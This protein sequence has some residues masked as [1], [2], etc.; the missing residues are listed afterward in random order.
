MDLENLGQLPL[1]YVAFL[2]SLTFHE[3]A[4]SWAA[5]LG[6][7]LTAYHAGQVTLNPAPHIRR[8][9]FGTVLVPLLSFLFGGWMLGWGSAPYD[10]FWEQRHPKRAAAMALAGPAA[11]FLLVLVSA[12][13]VKAGIAFGLF[14]IPS[15]FGFARIVDAAAPGVAEPLAAFV[16]VVFSLNL[17]LGT[18]NLIPVAPLDGHS[19]LGLILPEELHLR[20][21]AFVRQPMASLLGIVVAWRMFDSIFFPVFRTAI[22]TLYSGSFR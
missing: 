3:A 1:W 21:L 2:L 9:P 5:K 12:V 4:H 17:L 18:F 6:G 14:Q 22:L 7:D 10:P 15:G 16:S 19:A 13:V 8:E 11:N 20:F